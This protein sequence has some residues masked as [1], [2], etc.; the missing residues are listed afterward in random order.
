M[1]RK[2]SG[3]RFGHKKPFRALSE[4]ILGTRKPF[5]YLF[6][7]LCWVKAALSPNTLLPGLEGSHHT[8]HRRGRLAQRDASECC[9][10]HMLV[11]HRR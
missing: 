10:L 6:S 11:L 8:K 9:Y 4:A 2:V 7:E 3:K 5:D 1:H